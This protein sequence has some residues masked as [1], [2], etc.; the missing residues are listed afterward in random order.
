[1]VNRDAQAGGQISKGCVVVYSAGIHM[2]VDYIPRLTTGK[3]MPGICILVKLQAACPMTTCPT[4]AKWAYMPPMFCL[5]QII[6][7]AYRILNFFSCFFSRHLLNASS[8][9][10]KE[11]FVYGAFLFYWQ[12]LCSRIIRICH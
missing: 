10:L 11:K 12:N 7:A 2:Q 1:M 4:S 8:L 5:F 3:T 9:P 6:A